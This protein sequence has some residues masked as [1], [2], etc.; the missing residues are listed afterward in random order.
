MA[1]GLTVTILDRT[2][3]VEFTVP[4]LRESEAELGRPIVSAIRDDRGWRGF[5]FDEVEKLLWVQCR[6]QN[7]RLTRQK[8]ATDFE[9]HLTEKRG[10]L[11]EFQ[12]AL[13]TAFNQSD[14]VYRAP[15]AET[16]DEE[17]ESPRPTLAVVPPL[18]GGTSESQ[19]V[20]TGG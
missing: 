12:L 15:E 5:T 16:P 2:Y 3:D 4:I 13:L 17:E 9:K 19:E 1:S 8:L 14:L 7:K 20:L 6:R 11:Q 10:V 18:A